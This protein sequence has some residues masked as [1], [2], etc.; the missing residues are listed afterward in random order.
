M[1]TKLSFWKALYDRHGVDW[2]AIPSRFKNP[3][4]WCVLNVA[5]KSN[6]FKDNLVKNGS[7]ENGQIL[8]LLKD[9][10]LVEIIK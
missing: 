6:G 3:E 10:F 5:L 9:V 7:G 1:T 8:L 2:D 4:K